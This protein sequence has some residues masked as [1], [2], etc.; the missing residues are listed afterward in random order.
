MKGHV[1][2][3]GAGYVYVVELDRDADGKRRQRWRS[4]FRTKREAESALTD[5]LAALK[6]GEDVAPDKLTVGVFLT[7]R[8]LPSAAAT[9]R[10]G[11]LSL[12]E[13]LVRVH[14]VP[15]I[16][17]RRLQGL[18]GADLNRL[19]AQLAA[20]G[21]EEGR[22]PLGIHA[23]RR[24]HGVMH[25]ALRDAVRWKAVTRNVADDAD[26]PLASAQQREMSTWDAEQLGRFLE[27]ADGLAGERTAA[28]TRRSR[29][30]AECAYTRTRAA[31]PMQVALWYTAA[32]TGMRRGEVAGLRWS[33]LDLAEGTASVQ[34]ARVMVDGAVQVSSPKTARG[35]RV[36]SLDP[37]VVAELRRW[38][39]T[40][41]EE[42]MRYRTAWDDRE[43]TADGKGRPRHI[44]TH[45]VRS[46]GQGGED[47]YGVPIRPDWMC[48]AFRAL[49][50]EAALP[51][52]R[53][54]DLR[55]TWATLAF[56]ANAHPKTV[57]DQ[58]GHANISVTLDI[59]SHV[60]PGLQAEAT[61]RV[62]ALVQATRKAER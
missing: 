37:L 41:L 19:Y 27:A 16:G 11:T 33:D 39:A 45:L 48:R 53:L 61:S 56:Q 51:P 20:E 31:D 28:G 62:A 22:G 26:P 29:K 8:W 40:Q 5:A 42:F 30:G 35:R 14:I 25:R 36:V 24:V 55:H 49:A 17:G 59:Y 7:E 44:F 38:R 10:P 12:Y 58:L 23:V 54:H 4:G 43:P 1:R 9:L 3:R 50:T 21:S 52:I 32:L 2:R 13:T 47:L 18:T 15:A 34:R 57:S 6:A 60:L 46:A